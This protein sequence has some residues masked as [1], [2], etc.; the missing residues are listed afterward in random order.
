MLFRS[1][2]S[3]TASITNTLLT[4][5]GPEL[6]LFVDNGA[7]FGAFTDSLDIKTQRVGFASRIAINPLLESDPAKLVVYQTPPNPDADPT[8]PTALLNNL[9]NKTFL[10]SV[11][12]GIGNGQN[13]LSIGTSLTQMIQTQALQSSEKSSL[14]Q[15][16]KIVLSAV[17]TKFLSV[18]GV[19]TDQELANLTQLQSAY[20][21]NARVLS[22]ARDM[23]STLLGAV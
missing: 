17:E 19:S 3:L 21:A 12:S 2:S 14:K 13:P 10:P 8:R 15:G 22:A 23:L 11:S 7:N 18:S 9:N 5:P 1:V 20:A 16:Q 6:P 4:G